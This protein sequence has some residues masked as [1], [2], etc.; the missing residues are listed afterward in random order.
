MPDNLKSAVTKAHRYAPTLNEN[1]AKMARHY[2][3]AIVPARPYKPKDKAKA[4]NAVLIVERWIL[5]RLRRESFYTLAGLNARIKVLMAELNNRP[6]RLYPGSRR[7]QFELLDKPALMPLPGTMYEYIGGK[8]AKVGPDYHVFVPK[9]CLLC[10][11]H[12]SGQHGDHRGKWQC[13][14]HLSSQSTGNTAR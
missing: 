12:F 3:C 13:G 10:T 6:Q 4:E 9:A 5:M 11:T 2:G 14:Q 1:Y 8:W 7:E